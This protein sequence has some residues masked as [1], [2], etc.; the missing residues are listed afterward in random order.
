[1]QHQQQQQ[2][3][4]QAN[5]SQANQQQIIQQQ[6]IKSNNNNKRYSNQQQTRT[7]LTEIQTRRLSELY[8]GGMSSTGQDM[9][10]KMELA[11]NELGLSTDAVKVRKK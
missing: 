3:Q 11:A 1:M 9:M 10:G 2:E 7:V 6:H 4:Q 8:E 5:I